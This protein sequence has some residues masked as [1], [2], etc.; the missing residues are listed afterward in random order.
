MFDNPS[1]RSKRKIPNH[2]MVGDTLVSPTTKSIHINNFVLPL[3][4]AGS[5]FL[6]EHRNQR[7]TGAKPATLG[8]EPTEEIPTGGFPP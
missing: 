2:L 3:A 8:A 7:T 4:R 6:G 5:W 1:S